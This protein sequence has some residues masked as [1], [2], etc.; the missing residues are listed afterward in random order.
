MRN[1][2]RARDFIFGGLALVLMGV[3]TIILEKAYFTIN[4][5][6]TLKK[7]PIAFWLVV[8]IELSFGVYLLYL[9]IHRSKSI[10]KSKTEN[11]N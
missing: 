2:N 5:L 11:I 3:A 1:K 10:N 8:F 9:G 6:V 7:T 4:P